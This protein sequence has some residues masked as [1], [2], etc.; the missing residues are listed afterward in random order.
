MASV[1]PITVAVKVATI[2]KAARDRAAEAVREYLLTHTDLSGRDYVAIADAAIDA[3]TR[4]A[5][6]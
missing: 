3:A 4:T 5:R 6:D 2:D 1:A